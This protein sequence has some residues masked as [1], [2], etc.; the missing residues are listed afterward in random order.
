[1]HFNFKSLKICFIL[2][3]TFLVLMNRIFIKKLKQIARECENGDK[4]VVLT[5]KHNDRNNGNNK[6]S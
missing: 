3:C 6:S 4:D 1:M 5:E 2:F